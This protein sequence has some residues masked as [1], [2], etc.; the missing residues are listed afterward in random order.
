M[1]TKIQGYDFKIT[2]VPG[3]KLII[4]DTLSRMPNPNSGVHVS[5]DEHVD[6]I[7]IDECEDISIDLLNF[8]PAKQAENQTFN[9]HRPCHENSIRNHSWWLA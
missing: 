4:S 1:M 7:T 9:I 8:S 3:P 2:Y 6:E 5:I